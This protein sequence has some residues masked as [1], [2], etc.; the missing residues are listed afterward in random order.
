MQILFL[1]GYPTK[2]FLFLICT[3]YSIH[4]IL[5]VKYFFAMKTSLSGDSMYGDFRQIA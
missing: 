2:A 5:D 3:K 1:T 4:K